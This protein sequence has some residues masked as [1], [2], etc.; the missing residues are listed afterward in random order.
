MAPRITPIRD[1]LKAKK[2]VTEDG[3]WEWSGAT[4]KDGYGVMGIRRR[5]QFRV[6]RV[7]FSEYVGEIPIGLMVCHTC[8]NRKC[9]NPEHLFVG[10]AKDN[11]QDMLLKGRGFRPSGEDHPNSK[12]TK[13]QVEEI[14][15]LRSEGETLSSLA[16]KYGVSFQHISAICRGICWRTA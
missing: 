3:C 13:K 9:F 12:V 7:S 5:G 10:T 15:L 8:D 14:K 11:T 16:D 4:D 2:I 6:H 1:R